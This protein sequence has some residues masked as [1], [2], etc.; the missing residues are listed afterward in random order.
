MGDNPPP[1]HSRRTIGD[2]RGK[3]NK[4]QITLDFQPVHLVSSDIKNL[5][6]TSP[7]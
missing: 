4:G 2:F 1:P 5:V 3:T 7:K 6:L